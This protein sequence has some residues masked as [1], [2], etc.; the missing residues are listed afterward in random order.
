MSD[1]SQGTYTARRLISIEK[2]I[3]THLKS[4]IS[5]PCET[6]FIH[7]YINEI[8]IPNDLKKSVK[9]FATMFACASTYCVQFI[10]KKPS[11]IA[12]ASLLLSFEQHGLEWNKKCEEVTGLSKTNK[13]LVDLAVYIHEAARLIDSEANS[14]VES[15][16]ETWR[17]EG[18]YTRNMDNITVEIIPELSL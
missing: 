10:T 6:D 5:L 15:W 7:Y 3:L 2:Q 18:W 9:T 1:L 13:E 17:N 4:D 16:K 8:D 11:E 14:Y 12:A